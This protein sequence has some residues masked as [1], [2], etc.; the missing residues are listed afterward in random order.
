MPE[1]IE[2][3][4]GHPEKSPEPPQ[5]P[6]ATATA[7]GWPNP[8]AA[9]STRQPPAGPPPAPAEQTAG[10]AGGREVLWTRRNTIIAGAG[11]VASG[12][13]VYLAARALSVD[14]GADKREQE[15]NDWELPPMSGPP[16]RFK[17]F[18]RST[19]R[20]LLAMPAGV[21]LP[22]WFSEVHDVRRRR[23]WVLD[24][25]GAWVGGSDF[26]LMLESLRRTVVIHSAAVRI[27]RRAATLDGT[28]IYGVG[29]GG[30][31]EISEI[32]KT[33]ANLDADRPVLR[34]LKD[35]VLADP[36]PTAQITLDAHAVHAIDVRAE[37]KQFFS[38]W[39]LVFELLADG[40]P[41]N[42]PIRIDGRTFRTTGKASAYQAGLREEGE[43]EQLSAGRGRLVPAD[44]SGLMP[45]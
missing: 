4:D 45:S 2:G 7:A 13:G 1:E 24:N 41:V 30:S 34:E 44:P 21:R 33:S 10:D 11:L 31:G 5:Q 26:R 35:G 20:D 22:G 6:D 38:E 37:A 19:N 8:A 18:T 12:I 17:I 23:E 27:I 25:G 36:F 9:V 42:V 39:E 14:E 29:A 16:V 28:L 3:T 32:S 15:R 43:A 40:E